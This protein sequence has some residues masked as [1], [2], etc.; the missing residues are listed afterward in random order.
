MT[1]LPPIRPAAYLWGLVVSVAS[2][3]M[4][5]LA[6]IETQSARIADPAGHGWPFSVLF[7]SGAERTTGW[8]ELAAGGMFTAADHSVFQRLLWWHLGID[9]IFVISYGILLAGLVHAVFREGVGRQVGY[10]LV[11][12]TVLC[13]LLEDQLVASM[14]LGPAPTVVPGALSV[15]TTLK[16]GFLAATVLT[17]IIRAIVPYTS[18]RPDDPR[19]TL[20]RTVRALM[21]HRFSLAFVV[22]L[23]VLTVLSGSAVLEQLPDVQRRWVTD[24]ADGQRQ[25]LL[26]VLVLGTCAGLLALL[27]RERTRWARRHPM[28][29]GPA[30]EQPGLPVLGIWLVGPAVALFGA[31][32][33][34]L[35]TDAA[36]LTIRLV[37]FC[38]VSALVIVLSLLLRRWW[39]KHPAKRVPDRPQRFTTDELPTIR[40]TGHALALASLTIGGLGL[41]RSFTSMVILRPEL[42]TAGLTTEQTGRA[43]RLFALGILAVVLPWLI[44]LVIAAGRRPDTTPAVSAPAVSAPAGVAPLWPR[45]LVLAAVVGT[46]FYVAWHP[47]T[48]ARLGVSP[49][50]II[51]LAA[52]VG[53]PAASGLLI[54]DRPTAEVFRALGLR[55]TPL[56]SVLVICI[57]AV[58]A[59]SG[60][61][62]IDRVVDGSPSVPDP[63][64]WVR[65]RPSAN[66][67]VEHWESAEQGCELSV[68][69]H[70]VRPMI[71]VAAEG[72][73]ILAAYWTVKGLQAIE[74]GTSARAGCGARS[75][76]FS[77]GASGGSVGLTVARFSGTPGTPDT[78]QAVAAVQQMARPQPLAQGVV[79][80]F[81]RDPLYGATGVPIGSDGVAPDRTWAD[82][83][84]LLEIGW[85]GG[86]GAD[87]SGADSSGAD[88]WGTRDFLSPAST[89]SPATGPLILNSTSVADRCRVWVSQVSLPAPLAGGDQGCDRADATGPRTIDLLSAYA[90]DGRQP[91]A[92]DTSTADCLHGLPAVTAAMLT[93]R[94]PYVTPGGVVGPCSPV[95]ASGP[96]WPRTQLIDGGYTENSGLATITDLSV[97]WL[98]QVRSHNE[99]VMTSGSDEPLIIPFV[100]FLTNEEA[101]ASQLRPPARLQS[102]LLLPPAEYLSGQ[103][104]LNTNEALL[105][106]ASDVVATTSICPEVANSRLDC[107]A[108]SAQ[109]PHRV[110][111]V[112]RPAEPE[113]TAPLGW[114]LS[115]ASMAGMNAAMS[116]QAGTRCADQGSG[117]AS[118]DPACLRG[119]GAMGDLLGYLDRG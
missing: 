9:L 86:Y 106:R 4:V 75:V 35:F 7:G 50:A 70:R 8:R 19:P 110:I 39:S 73:G 49:V 115:D 33:A 37:I 32:T 83:A 88:S 25:A 66:D 84:R 42:Q 29:P 26:A 12:G 93:A 47:G 14:L 99:Q 67:L 30:P 6:E 3:A 116:T 81:V 98:A 78:A 71:M 48:V 109:F 108:I 90:T 64:N 68:D 22:P 52:L 101:G 57:V 117:P 58:G 43:D 51:G 80:T 18:A 102:E 31:V 5:A 105:R 92:G 44:G 96:A 112:D 11:L 40:F 91:V 63:A 20:R 76:L 55:R 107:T 56:V 53:I 95:G 60:Q 69:G 62:T 17:V 21:Q 36:V 100:V 2:A 74:D 114:V 15:A 1:P 85:S 27:G 113:V 94:F 10:G 54:Q 77:A 111:V 72:G 82:R 28:G 45:W 89:L 65:D 119:Y 13:D 34:P 104:T 87:S 118:I 24:G 23:L 59:L 79:G 16:W 97:A 41:I 38:A 103:G 46:F 61:T